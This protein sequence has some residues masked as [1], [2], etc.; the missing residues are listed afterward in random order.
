MINFDSTIYGSMLSFVV[1]LGYTF[2]YTSIFEEREFRE[3]KC[4]N[5]TS[6]IENI[7]C[8]QFLFNIII[9]ST[10]YLL[11]RNAILWLIS[12]L[13][14]SINGES[15]AARKKVCVIGAGP[16]GL[17]SLNQLV[18]RI[19]KFEPVVFEKNSDVG[20]LWIYTENG[21]TDE[22]GLLPVHSSVYKN[23][24]YFFICYA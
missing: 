18:S 19:D 12:L 6:K 7:H 10:V 23:L 16:S 4:K 2:S 5:N 9:L 1:N 22:H 14:F 20:G 11:L 17:G 13:I 3:Q 15:S 8:K 24:R 21:I